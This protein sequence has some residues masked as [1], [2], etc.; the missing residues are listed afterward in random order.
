MK[1]KGL[2]ALVWVVASSFSCGVY[3]APITLAPILP[4]IFSGGDGVNSDWVQV[5]RNWK[6]LSY[7]DPSS[8]YYNTNGINELRDH[9]AAMTMDRGSLGIN[10]GLYNTWA[11]TVANI[12]FADQVFNNVWGGVWGARPL[13][14]VLMDDYQDN[15]AAHF[16]GYLAIPVAGEYNLGVL[17]DDGFR[18]ELLGGGG[19]SVTLSKDGLNPPWDIASFTDPLL[20]SAGLYAFS[21]DS[22]EHWEA[23][24]ISLL[25]KTN[26]ADWS[27]IPDDR[28]FTHVPEPATWGMLL[29]GL[30]AMG[31]VMRRNTSGAGQPLPDANERE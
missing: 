8:P 22:Y 2:Q 26:S 24:V 10:Q 9:D 17:F 31:S 12:N 25:W 21:L 23:G 30:V 3:A 20:L 15:F 16:S 27:V 5:N 13:A 7:Y 1:I 28:F 6:G 19:A 4:G 18:F 14:P 11:G 29:I